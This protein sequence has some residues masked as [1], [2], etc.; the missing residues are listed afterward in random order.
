MNKKV[1]T[2][3]AASLMLFITAFT[4]N[5]QTRSYGD[6]VKYLPDGMGQGAY[7]LKVT[8]G[9][10]RTDSFLIMDQ[11]GYVSMMDSLQIYGG[12]KPDSIYRRLRSSLWCVNVIKPE[13]YG[14]VP[15]FEFTNKEYGAVM[16][17][18]YLSGLFTEDG[19]Q[20]IPVVI[21]GTP[22]RI[23]GEKD[24]P[25]VT[26]GDKSVWKFSRTYNTDTLETEQ[27]LAIEV[28]ADYY[29]T[30]AVKEGTNELRLVVAHK[31]EFATTTDFYKKELVRFTLVTAIPRVLT[32]EDF[33]TMLYEHST[34]DF[35]T[36]SFSKDVSDGQKNVF[37]QPLMAEDVT[38][39]SGKNQ[40]LYLKSANGYVVMKDG[41]VDANY[42][43]ALGYKYPKIVDDGT[44]QND[45]Q[46]AWRLVYYPS[47]DSVV[48]N[49]CEI[50][51]KVYGPYEDNGVYLPGEYDGLY[52]QTIWNYLTL[53]LCL[54]MP[55]VLRRNGCISTRTR[56]LI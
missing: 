11:Y 31:D 18:H 46:G 20:D 9:M 1:F 37:A 22:Q 43:N 49:V 48:I 10:N 32:A 13:V 6:T 21:D 4:A 53:W 44:A 42:Y 45:G 5:A 50:D 33:N 27:Y 39:T 15:G 12:T 8:I 52:N 7:H 36:L 56:W 23:K 3:L 51:H 54:C 40:Y 14:K 38:S 41:D 35:R 47:E 28:E 19:Y 2:L 34:P 17:F 29:M 25:L 16:A 30:F 24:L 26:G 55:A